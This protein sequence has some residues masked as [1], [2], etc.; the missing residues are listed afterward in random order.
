MKFIAILFCSLTFLFAMSSDFGLN[1]YSSV[2]V[3]NHNVRG[4]DARA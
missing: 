1:E 3:R 2:R 4:G